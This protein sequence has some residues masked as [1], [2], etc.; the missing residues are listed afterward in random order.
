MTLR[1]HRCPPR[2]PAATRRSAAVPLLAAALLGACAPGATDDRLAAGEAHWPAEAG[3]VPHAPSPAADTAAPEEAGTGAV[4][5]DGIDVAAAGAADGWRGIAPGLES[6]EL[7]VRDAGG[8]LV[9]RALAV[10]IDPAR[11]AFDVAYRPG[12]PQSLAAW[13]AETGADVVVNGGYFTE[14]HVATGLIVAGG[15]PSGASYGDFAGEFAVTAAGP[16]VRWLAERPHD[17]AEPLVAAVQAFPLLVRPDGQPAY[18][19]DGGLPARRT[20]IGQDAGGRIVVAVL[21]LGGLTLHALSTWL[22]G[23]PE[24]ALRI[25]FNLDGGASSGLLLPDGTGEPGLSAVPS[26]IVARA[27]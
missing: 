21:P 1:T 22:A 25:A 26:V 6:Q 13:Q 9:D 18:P 8:A 23:A 24:L 2:R 20:V 27:R 19:D 11:Y 15:T 10:R 4:D 12:E 16:E 3:A 7:A 14:A 5:G 17:P